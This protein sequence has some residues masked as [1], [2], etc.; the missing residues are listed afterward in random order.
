MRADTLPLLPAAATFVDVLVPVAL[1]QAYSYRVPAG[2]D[3]VPG[4]LVCVPLGAREATGV[5]WAD[6]VEVRAGLHNRLLIDKPNRH[7]VSLP[8]LAGSNASP[9]Y[10]ISVSHH[11]TIVGNYAFNLCCRGS[12]Y[13]YHHHL[14]FP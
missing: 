9:G 13:Y 10:E 6:H 5:V 7:E 4:D 3:L 8:N 14:I 11:I 1:D 2:L 12:L